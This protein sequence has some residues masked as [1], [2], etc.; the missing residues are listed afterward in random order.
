MSA[1]GFGS[2][3]GIVLPVRADPWSR[4][5]RRRSWLESHGYLCLIAVPLLVMML[6]QGL[7]ELSMLDG[8]AFSQSVQRVTSAYAGHSERQLH[9]VAARYGWLT[10]AFLYLVAMGGSSLIC[11]GTIVRVHGPRRLGMAIAVGGAVCLLL[12]MSMLAAAANGSALRRGVFD[13]TYQTLPA[14]LLGERF[15]SAVWF[16]VTAIN[17]LSNV[18]AVLAILAG[19]SCVAPPRPGQVA[20]LSHLAQRMRDLKVSLTAGSLLLATGVLHMGAWLNWPT[21]LAVSVPAAAELKTVALSITT[22]WG[23]ALSLMALAAYVPAEFLL[24]RRAKA[25]VSQTMAS[26]EDQ[27]VALRDYGFTITM[28]QSIRE[29]VTLLAPMLAVPVGEV[30]GSRL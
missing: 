15:L 28:P 11:A 4:F 25:I 1:R 26:P 22:Y 8:D 17:L 12:E 14:Q 7:F 19:C 10:S 6:A 21:A 3:L 9:E 29:F 5:W 30:L 27:Q 20:D 16:I 18:A 2:F 23:V 24:R 13:F